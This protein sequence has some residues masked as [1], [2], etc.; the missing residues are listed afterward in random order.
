MA[1]SS[2]RPTRGCARTFS[3][4]GGPY[5]AGGSAARGSEG[6]SGSSGSV[7][8][9]LG[10]PG[11]ILG[12]PTIDPWYR[13]SE[14]FPSVPSSLQPLP[15]DWEWLVIREDAAADVAWTPTFREI[16]DLQIQRKEIL[17]VPLIFDFQCS[18]A[19]GWETWLDRKLADEE[20]CN[21]LEPA[22]VLY[23]ILISRSSN[24]FRDTEAL[25]QLVRRWC[26]STHNIRGCREPLDVADIG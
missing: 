1:S 16:Q 26:P 15:A 7:L 5:V 6:D 10:P 17:T 18:R 14:R 23:S 24:M 21:R 20:F 22:G 11:D 25:R 13:S 19:I 2:K 4:E 9:S 8:G 3:G 12:R